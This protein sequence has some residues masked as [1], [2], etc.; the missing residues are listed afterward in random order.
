MY[1]SSLKHIIILYGGHPIFYTSWNIVITQ[2][3]KTRNERLLLK[4]HRH[5][6]SCQKLSCFFPSVGPMWVLV[7]SSHALNFASYFELL[8][9]QL[10][11]FSRPHTPCLRNPSPL[12]PINLP[13]PIQ[14]ISHLYFYSEKPYY[15]TTEIPFQ[16]FQLFC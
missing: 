16:H 12:H 7:E 14:N 11:F 15:S 8:P 1:T 9:M 2:K 4:C 5:S 13:Q 3:Q 6:L 10:S